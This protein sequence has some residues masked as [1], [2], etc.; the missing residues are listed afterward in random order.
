[1]RT[2]SELANFTL[3]NCGFFDFFD[4]EGGAKSFILLA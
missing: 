1:M 3:Q 4:K 2:N